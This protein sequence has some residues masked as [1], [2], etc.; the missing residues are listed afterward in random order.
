MKPLAVPA[1]PEWP[2]ID[3]AAVSYCVLGSGDTFI[4][5]PLLGDDAAFADA[6][7]DAQ[8]LG[9]TYCGCLGLTDDLDPLVYCQPDPACIGVMMLAAVE[10][11]RQLA[12]R[13]VPVHRGDSVAWLSGLMALEDPR[14][15]TH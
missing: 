3:K 4:M 5:A 15:G 13:L 7:A 9:F 11:I 2:L 10:F 8:R 1:V 6:Q 12:P 14:S